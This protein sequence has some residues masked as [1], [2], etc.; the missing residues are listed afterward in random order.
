MARR[1]HFS[2][3][4]PLLLWYNMTHV[5]RS[6]WNT[7]YHMMDM[8]KRI[9]LLHFPWIHGLLVALTLMFSACTTVASQSNSS[10]TLTGS[11]STAVQS[12]PIPMAGG[13]VTYV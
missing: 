12:T 5:K 3:G 8:P 9:K 10:N 6:L 1:N 2:T 4:I 11:Q 13:T 7:H